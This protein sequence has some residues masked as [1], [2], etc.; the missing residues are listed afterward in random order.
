MNTSNL[1]HTAPL[2]VV[3]SLPPSHSLVGGALR[4]IQALLMA[5]LKIQEPSE[6]TYHERS[7]VATPLLFSGKGIYTP[8]QDWNGYR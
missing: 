8:R 6:R 5:I 4:R 3:S 2:V 1:S 7:L